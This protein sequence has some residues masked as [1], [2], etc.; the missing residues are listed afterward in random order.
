MAEES[1]FLLSATGT[2]IEAIGMRRPMAPIAFGLKPT[3]NFSL[4]VDPRVT[5]SGQ[6]VRPKLLK[7]A[8]SC[9]RA[10]TCPRT[11]RV[12]GSSRLVGAVRIRSADCRSRPIADIFDCRL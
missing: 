6:E 11:C 12:K 1:V 8:A 7:E 2:P 4:E 10:R 5:A 9:F 3:A